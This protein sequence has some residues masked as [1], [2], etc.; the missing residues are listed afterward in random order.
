[1][2]D[3]EYNAQIERERAA[4]H[5]KR[6]EESPA[7]KVVYDGMMGLYKAST[8]QSEQLFAAISGRSV[9]TSEEKGKRNIL[10]PFSIPGYSEA[11]QEFSET[12]RMFNEKLIKKNGF[13]W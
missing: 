10:D 8:E 13:E 11:L 1:M 5:K 7:Y 6:S 9:T 2:N 4:Y 12:E 3:Y